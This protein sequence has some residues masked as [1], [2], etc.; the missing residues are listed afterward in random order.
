MFRRVGRET[1]GVGLLELP[2]LAPGRSAATF[3]L[4]PRMPISKDSVLP[5][6][7]Q[8][9]FDV[10]AEGG[11]VVPAAQICNRMASSLPEESV[12]GGFQCDA[13]PSGTV[14]LSHWTLITSESHVEHTQLCKVGECSARFGSQRETGAMMVVRVRPRFRL[15][16]C[17][18]ARASPVGSGTA[19]RG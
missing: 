12:V 7:G 11:N 5:S 16:T 1:E 6:H 17:E 4:G 2:L 19:R 8:R 15:S 18:P 14:L 9:R 13:L 10:D 3:L